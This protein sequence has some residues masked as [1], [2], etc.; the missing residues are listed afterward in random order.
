VPTLARR[1]LTT[2]RVDDAPSDGTGERDTGLH[3]TTTASTALT[4]AAAA[5]ADAQ[6]LL[7]T[8]VALLFAAGKPSDL[9]R[10]S[11]WKVP[12]VPVTGLPAQL[13]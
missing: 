10:V 8:W 6:T 4:A 12:A 13:T 7:W 2:L 5:A 3:C 1:A 9:G 11:Y